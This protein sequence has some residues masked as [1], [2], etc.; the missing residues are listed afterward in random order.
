MRAVPPHAIHIRGAGPFLLGS[1]LNDILSKLTVP[2]VVLFELDG[3]VDYSLVKAE[4][5]ALIIGV[6]RRVGMVYVAILDAEIARHETGVGVGTSVS[7][8]D[9]KLGKPLRFDDRVFD[10]RIRVYA[11]L[12]NGRFV[13]EDD[14]VVGV[15]VGIADLPRKVP[16][17]PSRRGGQKAKREPVKKPALRPLP[18]KPHGAK[19]ADL[20]RAAR[21]E[22]DSVRVEDGCFGAEN[23]SAVVSGDDQV[24][25]VVVDSKKKARRLA[26]LSVPG[27]IY[28][29][30][31]D[32]DEDKRH[33]IAIVS[34]RKSPTSTVFRVELVRIEGGK[35][36]RGNAIN[37][38]RVSRTQAKWIGAELDKIEL[39]IEL[40]ARSGMLHIG[41]LYLQRGQRRLS[42]L[43]VLLPKRLVA[44][45]RPKR[46]A[47]GTKDAGT[48]ATSEPRDAGVRRKTGP[49]KGRRRKLDA[50]RRR[51]R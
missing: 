43:S 13:V 21:I 3:V 4:A 44:R 2:R 48:D 28:A 33:E 16:A 1:P 50:G 29:A 12:P 30:T 51:R 5:D 26:H 11:K 46:P 37:A 39:L 27:L 34:K 40:S 20:I 18:C 25:L 47:S 15:L 19:R 45:R 17:A 31:I 10:P 24:S 36:V 23:A 8:L 49:G 7:E 22:G 9:A 32:A 41:G 14:K 35:P 42:N 38:Y 6:D